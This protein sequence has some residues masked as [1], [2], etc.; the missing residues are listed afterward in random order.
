MPQKVVIAGAHGFMGTRF[1]ELYRAAGDTVTTVGRRDADAT[2][3]DTD[4]IAR[5]VEGADIRMPAR[6]RSTGT[7]TT[8]RRP[9]TTAS[10]A[11]AS[12]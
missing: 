9:K 1:A 12:R 3:G 10:S 7:P 4:G 11:P 8:A 2:W 5:L 6:P